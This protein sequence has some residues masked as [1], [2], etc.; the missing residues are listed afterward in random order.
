MRQCWLSRMYI[1]VISHVSLVACI[2][3]YALVNIVINGLF[4]EF[5]LNYAQCVALLYCHNRTFWLYS[6]KKIFF[7]YSKYFDHAMSCRHYISCRHFFFFS[8]TMAA[9]A[10]LSRLSHARWSSAIKMGNF[11]INEIKREKSAY[12]N[13][14]DKRDRKAMAAI[15]LL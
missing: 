15:I 1:N 3:L 13:A 12:R 5:T 6:L 7:Y 2:L 8:L 4:S 14:W 10:F 9:M 11:V